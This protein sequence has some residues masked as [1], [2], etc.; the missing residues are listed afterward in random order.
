[1]TLVD[2][3]KLTK[4][5]WNSGFL[6]TD[7]ELNSRLAEIKGLIPTGGY[8]L[9][10]PFQLNQLEIIGE[11][12]ENAFLKFHARYKKLV[13]DQVSLREDMNSRFEN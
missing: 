7:T 2:A 10:N 1:M 6:E 11:E 12:L 13:A 5:I 9:K 4:P 3:D 8:K